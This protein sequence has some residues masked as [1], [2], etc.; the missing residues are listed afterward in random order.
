MIGA[1][2]LLGVVL[3]GAG[4]IGIAL[5]FAMCESSRAQYVLNDT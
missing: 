3:D 2:T 4:N 5:G 1:S